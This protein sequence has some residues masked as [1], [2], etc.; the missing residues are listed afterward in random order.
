VG[1]FQLP[2]VGCFGAYAVNGRRIA[3][4][5]VV[6]KATVQVELPADVKIINVEVLST[7]KLLVECLPAGMDPY[8][9]WRPH[10]VV[11]RCA[12]YSVVVYCRPS[13][14]FKIACGKH[15]MRIR[16]QLEA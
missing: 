10:H 5:H 13:Q 15:T 14:L 1:I 8:V 4:L 3:L 16:G 11:S 9:F 7:G 6:T 2:E 12:W